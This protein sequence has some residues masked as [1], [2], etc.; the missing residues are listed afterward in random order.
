MSPV[1]PNKEGSVNK[2]IKPAESSNSTEQNGT[3]SNE[4]TEQTNDENGGNGA[5]YV[6]L[7]T[8]PA[9]AATNQNDNE[10]DDD[11]DD[12]ETESEDE[13]DPDEHFAMFASSRAFEKKDDKNRAPAESNKPQYSHLFET[14]VFER[15]IA[16][17]SEEIHL[18][19][20]KCTTI[21]SLMQNF[22]IPDE[23]IPTW[24]K[25]V[26]EDAWKKNLLD[27]LTAKKLDLFDLD[28]K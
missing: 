28:K 25:L 17:E 27:S 22:K 9:S 21:N 2:E 26:P 23:S 7:N 10:D 11:D 6:L 13:I 5:D 19:E 3:E 1:P 12:D 15:K 18:D 8:N 4:T 20:N 16:L 24:A 14:D